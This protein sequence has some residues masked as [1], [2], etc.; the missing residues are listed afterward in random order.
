MSLFLI[1]RM[2]LGFQFSFLS[3]KNKYE[4]LSLF[5]QKKNS[6]TQH[7]TFTLS[8]L[9]MYLSLLSSLREFQITH[10][11]CLENR[12]LKSHKYYRNVQ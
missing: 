9:L 4:K 6:L 11:T 10:P 2:F 8:S 3:K 1:K 12:H 5:L 7:I